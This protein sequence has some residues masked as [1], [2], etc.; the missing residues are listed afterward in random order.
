MVAQGVS[1]TVKDMTTTWFVCS[2]IQLVLLTLYNEKSHFL[3]GKIFYF[4]NVRHAMQFNRKK[5]L[6]PAF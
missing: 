1:C 4:T 2:M 3:G 6:F 5:C